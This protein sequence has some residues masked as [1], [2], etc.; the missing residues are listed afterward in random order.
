MDPATAV[1]LAASIITFI[2]FSHSL[3][4]GSYQLYNSA[5]GLTTENTHISNVIKD[6]TEL[7]ADIRTNQT[8]RTGRHDKALAKLANQCND[9]SVQLTKILEKL[10]VREGDPPW[11]SLKA[12]WS[13]MRKEKDIA[14]LE[15]RLSM[16][17][18][19]ILL[20]VAFMLG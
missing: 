1:G 2:E 7:T 8:P 19:Q 13:S 6:L 15:K 16:Y 4:V 11:K 18:S 12:K 20:R 10:R 14:G 9:L 17:R 5:S 3:I